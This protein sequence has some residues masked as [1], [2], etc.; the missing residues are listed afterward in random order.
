MNERFDIL[1]QLK[2][3]KETPPESV[4]LKISVNLEKNG[5]FKPKRKKHYLH[6]IAIVLILLLWF[7]NEWFSLF[8]FGKS[9]IITGQQASNFSATAAVYPSRIYK[10]TISLPLYTYFVPFNFIASTHADASTISFSPTYEKNLVE[11]E[12]SQSSLDMRWMKTIN[13]EQLPLCIQLD[14]FNNQSGFHLFELPNTWFSVEILGAGFEKTFIPE[15]YKNLPIH[16]YH[17]GTTVAYFSNNL[18]AGTGFFFHNIHAPNT[19]KYSKYETFVK[20]Y[21]MGIDSIVFVQSELD[22]ISFSPLVFVGY[23]PVY[24]SVLK[25]YFIQHQ[26][27]YHFVEVPIFVGF[28][29]RF[30]RLGF[31]A[32]LGLGIN[33]RQN[34]KL[35]TKERFSKE[36]GFTPVDWEPFHF[37]MS[38]SFYN[39]TIKG[40]I[41][42]HFLPSWSAGLNVQ[43]R[44]YLSPI[45]ENEGKNLNYPYSFG[46]N[47]SISKEL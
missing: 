9:R 7:F 13:L 23:H 21:T 26:D 16:G 18:Y 39:F 6:L 47:F 20:D 41:F 35:Y 12:I 34:M 38:P 44:N 37:T 36:Y 11:S 14:S 10:Q 29:N 42:Y 24:D 28:Q 8:H 1:E 31:K 15:L 33:F 27:V 43:F 4:W 46:M 45:F 2:G 40:G 5:F 22:K 3:Y 17:W 32:E 30:N 19:Y 25:S